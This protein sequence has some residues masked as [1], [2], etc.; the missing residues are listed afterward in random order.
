LTA[1]EF[2][3]GLHQGPAEPVRAAVGR[4]VELLDVA[5][6]RVLP[7]RGAEAQ[8]DQSVGAVPLEQ[9]G[10]LV[11]GEQR[12]DALGDRAR[13]RRRVVELGAC[14]ASSGAPAATRPAPS[15]AC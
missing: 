7:R 13:P 1:G 5:L 4:H 6:E 12:P 9:D 3:R 11:D 14:A 10:D 2:D 8:H 15:T